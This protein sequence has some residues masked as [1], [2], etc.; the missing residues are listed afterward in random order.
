MNLPA[1]FQPTAIERSLAPGGDLSEESTQVK[2]CAVC[3]ARAGSL[4][5]FC[6]PN[7][8]AIIQPRPL[9]GLQNSGPANFCCPG[10]LKEGGDRRFA[11]I[12]ATFERSASNLLYRTHLLP[13]RAWW[14]VHGL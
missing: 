13:Q 11:H 8:D 10:E 4:W 5:F 14:V 1:P 6:R 3:S 9:L 7:M 12:T 2:R